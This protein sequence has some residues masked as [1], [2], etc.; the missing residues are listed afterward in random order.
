MDK[1]RAE[2]IA[3]CPSMVNVTYNGT[4]IY[5]ENVNKNTE[6]ANIHFLKNPKNSREVSLTNLKEH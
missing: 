5:I 6:T 2:E 1:Q 3:S 4:P